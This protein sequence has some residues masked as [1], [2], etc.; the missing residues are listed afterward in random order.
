MLFPVRALALLGTVPCH[1]TS[2]ADHVPGL[3]KEGILWAITAEAPPKPRQSLVLTPEES[4]YTSLS[5]SPGLV[6]L[7]WSRV[8]S[9]GH[10]IASRARSAQAAKYEK[11]VHQGPTD[12]SQSHTHVH[13][14]HDR[15]PP[16]I[17][18]R[19]EAAAEQVRVPVVRDGRERRR[20]VAR[21]RLFERRP[22]RWRWREGLQG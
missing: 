1:A 9:G 22:W 7:S 19:V 14:L 18:S 21:G 12:S 3:G 6:L 5:F 13:N 17:R 15:L 4:H 16:A 10:S 20:V 11:P 2:A 8:W